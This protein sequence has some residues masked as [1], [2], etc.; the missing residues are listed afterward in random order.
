M[1]NREIKFRVWNNYTKRYESKGF[2]TSSY[3]G[4]NYILRGVMEHEQNE[5]EYGDDGENVVFEQFIG[6]TDFKGTKIYEGDI[7]EFPFEMGIAYVIHDGFRFAVKSP[8][9]EA[10]DY[11][12]RSVLEQAY[13]IGNIH[14]NPE[15]LCQ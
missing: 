6:L 2:L 10:I 1:G 5:D 13:I 14:E 7:L 15:L 3:E 11:E 4:G 8:G 9:S 12:G